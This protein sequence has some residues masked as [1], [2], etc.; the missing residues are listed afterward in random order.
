LSSGPIQQRLVGCGRLTEHPPPTAG[1]APT[2]TEGPASE[3]APPPSGAAPRCHT[4]QLSAHLGGPGPA[5][6]GEHGERTVP[7]IYTNVS[8]QPCTLRGAPDVELHG[9]DDPNGP[10][11]EMSV[12]DTGSTAVTLG[13]GGTATASIVIREDSQGRTG[14]GGSTDWT[15]TQPVSTPPGETATLSTPWTAGGTVLREDSSTHPDE[16]V[17]PFTALTR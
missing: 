9:P 15:P 17:Q 16:Y 3:A 12:R 2:A 1:S 10:V 4:E 6:N 11:F 7:L 13:P 5:R 14:H 8:D